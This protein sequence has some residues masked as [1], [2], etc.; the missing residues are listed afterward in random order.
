MTCYQDENTVETKIKK[1]QYKNLAV[2]K[3]TKIKLMDKFKSTLS[4]NQIFVV[5]SIIP[6]HERIIRQTVT[7]THDRNRQ[8]SINICKSNNMLFY[9]CDSLYYW[10]TKL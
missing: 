2:E 5:K 8:V 7:L 1:L 4:S 10:E 3:K 6:A 9:L